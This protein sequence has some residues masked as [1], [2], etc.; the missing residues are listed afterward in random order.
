MPS[1][2]SDTP[3]SQG[4]DLRR[5]RKIPRRTGSRR[6]TGIVET[7]RAVNPLGWIAG[8]LRCRPQVRRFSEGPAPRPD[9]DSLG[10]FPWRG[11]RGT[12]DRGVGQAAGGGQPP[13]GLKPV[14]D[15]IRRMPPFGSP[16]R[17]RVARPNDAKRRRRRVVQVDPPHGGTDARFPRQG[18][19][20]G[21][22]AA[23]ASWVHGRPGIAGLHPAAGRA[24]RGPLNGFPGALAGVLRH[25]IGGGR[26]R[27]SETSATGLSDAAK[28]GEPAYPL[29]P[30]FAG[31]RQGLAR[32][33]PP[34]SIPR[35]PA[36]RRSSR[37]GL[38]PLPPWRRALMADR[39]TITA[40][41]RARRLAGPRPQPPVSSC[42]RWPGPRWRA[43]GCGP[44][45]PPCR[46]PR[47]GP[48]TPLGPPHWLSGTPSK[49]A[50]SITKLVVVPEARTHR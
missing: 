14:A 27:L 42:R 8:A 12:A 25:R 30:R 6:S 38:V 34:P 15:Q 46:D 48:Y 50:R 35:R 3:P 40:A 21:S 17:G 29:G 20:R 32:G 39:R 1:W 37:S 22:V 18:R 26:R 23:P 19:W 2:V 13:A 45:W 43:R 31:P 44:L 16:K 24:S 5:L 4:R 7:E 41:A 33:A 9:A 47:R 28:A 11:L 49:S 10:P 36:L